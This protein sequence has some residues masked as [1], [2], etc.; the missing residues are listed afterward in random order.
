[1]FRQNLPQYFIPPYYL[2]LLLMA[3]LDILAKIYF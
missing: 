3:G 1:M 2:T